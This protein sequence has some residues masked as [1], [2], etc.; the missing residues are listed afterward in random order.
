[1]IARPAAAAAAAVEAPV[2]AVAAGVTLVQTACTTLL[3]LLL[4][5]W[6]CFSSVIFVCTAQLGS[7]ISICSYSRCYNHLR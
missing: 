4:L 7:C 2:P 5:L 6:R 3:L 1:L